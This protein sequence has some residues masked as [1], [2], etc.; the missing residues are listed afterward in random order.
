MQFDS[1]DVERHFAILAP[2]RAFQCPAL[3]YAIFSASARHI[4]R[5]KHLSMKSKMPMQGTR[6]DI[7]SEVALEYQSLCISHL[8]ALSGDPLEV[9]DENLLAASVILRFYEELDG[10]SN[11]TSTKNQAN[12]L[13]VPLVGVDEETHF[14][15]T[16]FFLTAQAEQAVRE[17]GFRNAAFWVGVRQKVHIAF[18][19]QIRIQFDFNCFNNSIYKTLEPADDSTWANRTVLLCA[20]ILAYCY[21]DEQSL[22]NYTRLR[23]FSENWYAYKPSSFN[24]IYSQAPNP[25]RKEVFPQIWFLGDC[26]GELYAL[27]DS[28]NVF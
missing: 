18:I 25:G 20:E 26:H 4:S 15:G 6:P 2:H 19:N 17:R 22:E 7:G 10:R 13:K 23:N 3:R 24:P 27:C 28:M 21:G 14:K 8:M 9:Q 1:C 12:S 11:I 5:R 16:L